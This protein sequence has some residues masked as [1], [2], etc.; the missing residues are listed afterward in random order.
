MNISE[1]VF[2]EG[3]RGIISRGVK[4]AGRTAANMGDKFLMGALGDKRAEGRWDH[5][6]ATK[7]L[8]DKWENFVG[9]KER[10]G[11]KN[12]S[13]RPTIGNLVQFLK[14]ALGLE[15]SPEQLTSIASPAVVDNDNNNV[16]ESFTSSSSEKDYFAHLR[17]VIKEENEGIANLMKAVFDPDV[18][19]PRMADIFIDAGLMQKNDPD[20]KDG[21]EEKKDTEDYTKLTAERHY[22]DI[23][24]MEEYLA[25]NGVTGTE[26]RSLQEFTR[27]GISRLDTNSRIF[28]VIGMVAF[29]TLKAIQGNKAKSGEQIQNIT[30]SGHAINLRTFKEGIKHKIVGEDIKH[31][32]E[33]SQEQMY[34]ELQNGSDDGKKLLILVEAVSSS[35][36][37]RKKAD[38]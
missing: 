4:N 6:V 12:I 31:L 28:K 1:D 7:Y 9:R 3:L 5:R 16:N 22:I 19:F 11:D 30:P 13:E 23:N 17:F 15:L 35:I 8:R 32:K 20:N 36:E 26:M 24:I 37:D 2:T 10:M 14:V 34:E 33:L 21:A 18:L 38:V 29:A 25:T 27:R